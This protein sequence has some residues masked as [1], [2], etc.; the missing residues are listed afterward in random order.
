MLIIEHNFET[1]SK[2]QRPG[3]NSFPVSYIGFAT[4]DEL[5]AAIGLAKSCEQKLEFHSC[6]E[7]YNTSHWIS[8]TG[9]QW[10][11]NQGYNCR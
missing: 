11:H 2:K 1:T 7:A 8:T 5:L 9:E 10:Q 6:V 3:V 4:D